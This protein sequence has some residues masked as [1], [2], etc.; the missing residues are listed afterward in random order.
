MSMLTNPYL[1]EQTHSQSRSRELQTVIPDIG[2]LV[3]T[4]HG[5]CR[6]SNAHI[7]AQVKIELSF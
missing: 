7:V 4:V 6:G 1:K 3:E 5:G 2:S